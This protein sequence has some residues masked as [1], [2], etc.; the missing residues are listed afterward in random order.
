M[1]HDD[2]SSEAILSTPPP[3]A[4]IR[5]HYGTGRFQFGDLR[6]PPESESGGPYPVVIGVHGGYYRAKYGL[7]YFGHACSALT[8]VGMATWNI[9]YRR[10]GYP[11]GGW[12]GTFQD[13]AAAAD[14]LRPLSEKYPLDLTRV[15]ALGHSAGGHL[16]CW[17]AARS[18]IGKGSQ[19]YTGDPLPLSAAVSLAGVLDLRRAVELGLSRG[20]VKRLLGGAPAQV[21]SRYHEASPS[22]LL[23]LGVPQILIHGTA[24][25]SVPYEMSRDYA[26]AARAGGDSVELVTLP[27]CGHFAIVDPLASEWNVVRESVLRAIR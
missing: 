12:P 23:P 25:T 11:G 9:E 26:A 4:D 15:V 14:Y 16:A 13:V 27:D 7:T 10:L 1:S 5:L 20:V 22:E 24:D 19:I 2:T 17:L 18:R 6:L 8:T 21:P 3:E